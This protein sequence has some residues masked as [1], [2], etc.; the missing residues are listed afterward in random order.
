MMDRGEESEDDDTFDSEIEVGDPEPM[1]NPSMRASLSNM[2]P[3]F[4]PAFVDSTPSAKKVHFADPDGSSLHQTPSSA[5][6]FPTSGSGLPPSGLS[7]PSQEGRTRTVPSQTK[8]SKLRTGGK[9]EALR[10]APSKHRR[11]TKA[12][13]K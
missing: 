2:S 3:D 13:H 10:V 7:A 5:Q 6:A 9:E 12:P 11:K 8:S 1:A 4:L